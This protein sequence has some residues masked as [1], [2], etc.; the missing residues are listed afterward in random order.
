MLSYIYTTK[1]STQMVEYSER[2]EH[3][4]IA[5]HTEEREILVDMVL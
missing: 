3:S 1:W 4:Y 2:V 5:T